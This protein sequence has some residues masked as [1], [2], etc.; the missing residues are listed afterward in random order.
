MT[1]FLRRTIG[2][3]VVVAVAALCW[4]LFSATAKEESPAET[5]VSVV[6][7][8]GSYAVVDMNR[9]MQTSDAAK[10]IAANVESK[11]KEY[12][13]QITK[14]EEDLRSF[15]TAVMKEKDKLTQE[16]LE[17]KRKEFESKMASAQKLVQEKKGILDQAFGQSMD[18]LRGEALKIVADK[19]REKKLTAVFAQEALVI[20]EKELDMTEVVLETL[21][22]KVKKIPVVWSS[23]KDGKQG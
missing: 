11:R 10:D 18:K 6:G 17:K 9:I 1:P 19:A 4:S 5:S 21:N 13:A 22:D 15:E 20:V 16:Q 23:P 2:A 14:I 7:S 8:G 12:Q 3:I